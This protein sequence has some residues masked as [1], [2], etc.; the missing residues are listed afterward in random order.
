MVAV[1]AFAFLLVIGP[2]A[3]AASASEPGGK[4]GAVS[5]LHPLASSFSASVTFQGAPTGDHATP[6]SAIQSSF[7][8]SF[9]SV[10]TWNSPGQATLITQAVVAVLF[11]GAVVGT[12]SNTINGATPNVTGQITLTSDFTQDKYLFEGVYQLVASL[13][14]HGQAIY[15]TT[16]YVWVQAPGHFTVVN[17]A[18]ILIGLYEIWQI[19]ALGSAR[20]ARKQLGLDSPPKKESP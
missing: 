5:N 3:S 20:V 8:S 10:F 15:N 16:F 6:G 19:V 4:S 1:L 12:T 13:F 11:L 17:I 2:L 9:V 14:D 18:L 7:G